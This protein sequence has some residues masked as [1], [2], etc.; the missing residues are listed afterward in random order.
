MER[1]NIQLETGR[2]FR[3][4]SFEDNLREVKEHGANG[5]SKRIEGVGDNWHCHPEFELT[6]FQ[7]GKGFRFI[8]D[9]T[10][11]FEGPEAVLIGPLLPH[12]WR[13]Q[14]CS[15]YSL[16]FSSYGLEH[17]SSIESGYLTTQLDELSRNGLLLTGEVSQKIAA[18]MSSFT[19]RSYFGQLAA[20]YELLDAITSSPET[21][22]E[23]LS[24]KVI[25]SRQ[26]GRSNQSLQTAIQFL[27]ENYA[28][29][30]SL[31][32]LLRK[33]GMSRSTFCR[34][35]KKQTGKSFSHLLQEIRISNACRMLITTDNRISEISMDTGFN[36]LA[37]FNRVFRSL[38]EC[39]P[40]EYRRRKDVDENSSMILSN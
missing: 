2:F 25:V 24:S 9:H 37:H 23:R 22:Q 6:F 27:L 5:Q 15:G 35:I 39:S 33:V 32:A 38:R 1:E 34:E 30:I 26:G 16:Q 19:E 20:V 29:D 7:S 12:L 10:D 31:P 17:L 14:Q 36:N 21:E 18:I 3:F 13:T 40:S 8:G 11:A 28:E 4:L